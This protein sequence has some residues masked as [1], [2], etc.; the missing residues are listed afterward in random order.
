MI[1][2]VLLLMVAVFGMVL[3][4]VLTLE[5]TMPTEPLT[6]A[7]R[8]WQTGLSALLGLVGVAISIILQGHQADVQQ[9]TQATREA[10]TLAVAMQRE[11]LEHFPS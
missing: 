10:I 3:A 9:R 5:I 4:L 1:A 7:L 8:N 6:V 2:F 11:Q